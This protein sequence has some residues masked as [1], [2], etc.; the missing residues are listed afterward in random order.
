MKREPEQSI[1]PRDFPI[2]MP[3]TPFSAHC[4]NCK[5]AWVHREKS[6][7]PVCPKCGV[8]GFWAV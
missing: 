5:I 8:L 2:D 7:D 4:M 6:K 3:T 1:L